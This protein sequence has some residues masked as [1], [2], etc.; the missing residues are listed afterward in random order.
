M[1]KVKQVSQK[2][3]ERVLKQQINIPAMAGKLKELGFGTQVIVEKVS[4]VKDFIALRTAP[5]RIV[6]LPDG[7][8]RDKYLSALTGKNYD[9]APAELEKY[10][11]W[12]EAEKY[13]AQYGMQASPEELMTLLDTSKYNP[14]IVEGAKI[15][16]LKLDNWYWTRQQ[17]AGDP[18]F[19][20]VVGF[21][22]GYVGDN[23]KNNNNCVRPVRLS[24]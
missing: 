18:D 5:D 8:F 14:A 1:E 6:K 21:Y 3:L 22:D 4:S 9:F 16:N 7:W 10:S 2:Q 12:E 23:H 17:Y 15:L 20:R 24:Q 13:A 19:A 11:S